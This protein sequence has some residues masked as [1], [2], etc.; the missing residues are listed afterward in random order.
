MTATGTLERARYS[1]RIPPAA[2]VKRK[3][4]SPGDVATCAYVVCHPPAPTYT[5]GLRIPRHWIYIPTAGP[6]DATLP[7]VDKAKKTE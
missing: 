6:S 1:L 5:C 4:S 7:Q 2:E 3:Y